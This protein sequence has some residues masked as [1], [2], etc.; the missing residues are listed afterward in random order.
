MTHHV[1][2]WTLRCIPAMML[3]A[4]AMPSMAQAPAAKP[5]AKP[6]A[7]ENYASFTGNATSGKKV[8]AQCMAC[9]S[10]KAGQNKVGPSLYNIV[11]RK[12]GQV[13]GFAYSAAN[14]NSGLVWTEK[15]LFTYLK[16]PRGTVPGTKMAFAGVPDAQKRADVI[17][18]LKVNGAI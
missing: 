14:K 17:A 4:F 5:A 16:N 11:G 6:A 9:H 10:Q 12:A 13:P 3:V 2:L 7:A 15:Q 8:F 18:Y 1:N